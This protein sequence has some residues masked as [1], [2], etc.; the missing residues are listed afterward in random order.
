MSLAV[1][2]RNLPVAKSGFRLPACGQP[3]TD[4]WDCCKMYFL[5]QSHTGIVQKL[6]YGRQRMARRTLKASYLVSREAVRKTSWVEASITG[7]FSA[8]AVTCSGAV[9]TR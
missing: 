9:S 1:P 3:M 5:Q 8:A 4:E 2:G 6:C 7:A